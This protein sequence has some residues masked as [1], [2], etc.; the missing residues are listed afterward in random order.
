MKEWKYKPIYHKKEI[1]AE[2]EQV[3]KL[4]RLK[5]IYLLSSHLWMIQLSN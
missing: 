5:I 4:L 2:S 1:D 3:Q